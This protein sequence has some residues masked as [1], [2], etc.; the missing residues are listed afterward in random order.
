MSLSHT[1]R[2]LVLVLACLP[3]AWAQAQGGTD[4]QLA[5]QYLQQGEYDKA[6]LYYEKLYKAQP[7]SYFYEQLYKSYVALKQYDDAEKLAKERMRRQDGDP[8]YLVD[9]GELKKLQGDDDRAKQQ[10]NKAIKAVKADQGSIRRLANAFVNNNELDYALETYERGRKLLND[11]AT[12]FFYETASIRAA[13]G[14]V[15][16]M[17]SDYMDLVQANPAYLQAVQNGLARFIDFT[18]TDERSD[19]LRTELLRRIQKTPDNTLFQE[20]LIWM[21]IQRK[22]LESAYVQSKAMDKRFKEGGQRLMA[23]GDMAVTNKEWDV[24]TKCYQYVVALGPG[25]NWYTAARIGQVTAMDAQVRDQADPPKDQLDALEKNYAGTLDE[26]GRTPANVKLISGLARL[27]AYYLNDID[28][29]EALLQQA[30]TMP[31]LPP[32]TQAQLK[33]DLGDIEVLG[34]DIWDASLLYSQVTLD[35]K[36]DMLGSDARLRNAKVSFYTGDFLWAKAQL[37]ILKAGTS[38]LIANDA[39]ELSLLISDNLGEDTVSV[40]LQLYAKA[41]LLTFQHKYGP[42]VAVLDTLSAR[43]PMHAIGD[44]VLYE[45]YHIAKARHQYPEAAGF[46]EK[47]VE[48]YPNGILVDNAMYDLGLLYENGLKDDEQAKKWFGK[49]LFEQTGSIFVP[50]AREHYRRL[51]GD[52]D[53]QDTPEQKLLNGPTP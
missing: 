39:M 12:G 5:A 17:I 25:T 27:K 44:R 4:E 3:C 29:A 48:L 22:D 16:G 30:I 40:P 43:F 41:E 10:F 38:K 52:L 28:S 32:Q 31:G 47:V 9:I 49:L 33:L 36:K 19:L 11:D 34:G 37:D 1:F 51:R 14:D 6:V 26:L 15:A 13:K 35:F 8:G 24:A 46:L 50:D 21:Y 20:M 45:R 18:A 53:K 2:S 7:T 23:L 42:A